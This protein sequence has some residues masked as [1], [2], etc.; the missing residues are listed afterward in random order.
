[1]SSSMI[2]QFLGALGYV[3]FCPNPNSQE[4]SRLTNNRLIIKS[5][6]RAA[7][8]ATICPARPSPPRWVPKRLP[9]PSRSQRSSNFLWP[10]RSHAH[11]CSRLTRQF[12]TAVSKAAWWPWPL[13]LKVVSESR[14]TWATSTNFGLPRPLCS[15]LR[16]DVR[17]RQA[18]VRQN[19]RLMPPPIMA[20]HNKM[21][22]VVLV[23]GD[24]WWWR[25]H[26]AVIDKWY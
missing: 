7:A 8:A 5:W 24:D 4:V 23:V 20:G 2:G 9:P 12:N 10:T 21:M 19:H 16:P 17:G 1:M 22:M 25:Q 3:M 26:L 13:T 6:R 14:V 15:R 18:D 11:R